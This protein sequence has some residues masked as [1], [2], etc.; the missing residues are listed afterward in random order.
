MASSS[1]RTC[2]ST[3]AAN[4][5]N[6]ELVIAERQKRKLL[7][8]M[9]KHPNQFVKE[10]HPALTRKQ[11]IITFEILE[12]I[13]KVANVFTQKQ[14]ALTCKRIYDTKL[15]FFKTYDSQVLNLPPSVF[16]GCCIRHI[17]TNTY[18]GY[19]EAFELVRYDGTIE[20]I[21]PKNINHSA[22]TIYRNYHI[23]DISERL[24]NSIFVEIRIVS[25][26][27]SSPYSNPIH[28]FKN[29]ERRGVKRH[30]VISK[31]I[32]NP[33]GQRRISLIDDRQRIIKHAAVGQV[34]LKYEY[35]ES[36]YEDDIYTL[37]NDYAFDYECSTINTTGRC[38]K[39]QRR[40][41]SIHKFI[42]T[43]DALIFFK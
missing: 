29:S 21:S 35:E 31:A 43:T 26:S 39:Q 28:F 41:T 9:K 18:P 32:E 13:W 2:A 10:H 8:K 27:P 7:K 16:K 34:S 1:S 20:K 12:E 36:L 42:I 24:R 17:I 5:S 25:S 11:Y 22:H 19:I 4:G 40:T 38:V 3:G 23:Y 14:M 15:D 33:N 6:R 37:H 30:D